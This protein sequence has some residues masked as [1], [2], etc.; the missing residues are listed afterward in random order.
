MFLYILIT[1]ADTNVNFFDRCVRQQSPTKGDECQKI[2]AIDF[3]IVI[4]L[5]IRR[6]DQTQR[7]DI[8]FEKFYEKFLRAFHQRTSF[9]YGAEK[10]RGAVLLTDYYEKD[11]IKIRKMFGDHDITQKDLEET[12]YNSL[13]GVG[14]HT[15][16]DKVLKSLSTMAKADGRPGT[17][18]I[19]LGEYCIVPFMIFVSL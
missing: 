5:S 1:G 13:T 12:P 8:K 10:V 3:A 2:G 6:G 19:V 7:S 11:K 18:K 14:G 15:Y 9:P 4:D 17:Q 16:V